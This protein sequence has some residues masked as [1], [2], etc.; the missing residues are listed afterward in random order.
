M[1]S[2]RNIFL[3]YFNVREFRKD[4]LYK[5][6]FFMSKAYLTLPCPYQDI[7]F[8][9]SNYRFKYMPL[10]YNCKR[11]FEN[12]EQMKNKVNETKLIKK[13]IK[14]QKY[15]PYKYLIEE[16]LEAALDPVINHLYQDKIIF[17]KNCDSLIFQW[18][19]YVK[20][21]GFYE[22]IKKKYPIPFN[23][24]ETFINKKN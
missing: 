16:I 9:I 2:Y 19:K 15:S 7:L 4:N 8:I 22:I 23:Y 12:D 20:L 21:T 5:K 3:K 17:S 14:K 1:L 24:C 18:I 10:K 13:W 11:F 6:A